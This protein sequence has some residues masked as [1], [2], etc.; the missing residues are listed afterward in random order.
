MDVSVLA[1][2]VYPGESHPVLAIHGIS[3]HRK[4]WLWLHAAAPELSLLAP[5]LRGRADSVGLAGPYTR[6]H[7]V[8]DLVRLLDDEGLDRVDVIGM[9][10]GGFVG[11]ALAA[12]HPRRVR[13]LTL[14]DGGPPMTPPPGLT[15]A[16]IG[17]AFAGRLGRLQRE[18]A[19]VEE[20]RDYFCGDIAPLLEPDDPVLLRYLAHDLDAQGQVRLR[21]EALIEDGADIWFG[22]DLF[23]VYDGPTRVLTAAWSVGAGSAPAYG[24]QQIADLR[25]RGIP[26]SV[27]NEVDHAGIIMTSRGATAVAAVLREAIA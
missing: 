5:D 4:L 1:H 10:M 7:H 23:G 8:S 22:P 16:T 12:A 24:A 11:A 18:W 20:F 13:S 6:E 19:S 17:A 14:V 27:V 26:V 3:S 15:P 9:S 25:A 2:E 21:G